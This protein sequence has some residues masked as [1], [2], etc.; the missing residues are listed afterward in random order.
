MALPDLRSHNTI[1]W[2]HLRR[3][4]SQRPRLCNHRTVELGNDMTRSTT[5]WSTWPPY[6][7]FFTW[8]ELEGSAAEGVV[9]GKGDSGNP[10]AV[11]CHRYGSMG[12]T[13]YVQNWEFA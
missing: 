8:E 3:A 1:R 7:D 11:F 12:P 10:E 5:T 13:L 4:R 2:T 6:G 9:C